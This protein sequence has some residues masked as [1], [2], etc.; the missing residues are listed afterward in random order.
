METLME[1]R[2]QKILAQA[3]YGS[4]RSCE[5]LITQGR[6]RV[7]GVVAGLGQKADVARDAITVDGEAL[8]APERPTYILL[9]KP[10]DVVS[11]RE[12]QGDRRTVIDLVPAK[13]RLYPVGRLDM[14][15]EGLILLTNDGELANQLTHPR[16]GVE[17][18][19]RVLVKGHPEESRLEVW[20]RGV[21]LPDD[22]R[23]TRPAQVTREAEAGPST[24]LRVIMREGRKHEIRDIGL[25]LGMPVQ[26]LIRVRL[27]GLEL[28]DL[29]PGAWRHLAPAEV[30][31]LKTNA[32]APRR[33][34]STPR[35]AP[36]HRAEGERPAADRADDRPRRAPG[37]A[38]PTGSA[39]PVSAQRAPAPRADDRRP[40]KK[41]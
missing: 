10:R 41:R 33:K 20:R 24:W 6:V 23:P 37:S 12:A 29:K 38:R 34:P 9:H 18:E 13:V 14:D 7:N 19:Y 11:S 25:T 16:F 31:A 40:P 8:P 28:G 3:G 2:L 26:R 39:R 36:T 15:S 5:E 35:R 1:E 32:T 30:Q 27:G 22:P 4:R 17:K 21:M